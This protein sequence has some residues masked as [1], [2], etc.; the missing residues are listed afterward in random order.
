LSIENPAERL[1]ET[2][3]RADAIKHSP[4]SVVTFAVLDLM[5]RTPYGVEQIFVDV[6][7]RKASLVITNVPGPTVAVTLA[8]RQLR[9][10]IGW[11]PEPGD[12]GLGLSIISYDGELTIGL[13]CDEKLVHSPRALLADIA[14]ELDAL[15]SGRT[16]ELAETRSVTLSV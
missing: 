2:K 7:A 6:F 11:P 10:T 12:V 4:E 3:R 9:V 14:D 8:G 15:I 1:V 13:M 5:G 16:L